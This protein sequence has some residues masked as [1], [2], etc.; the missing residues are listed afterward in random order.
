M[1]LDS[2]SISGLARMLDFKAITVCSFDCFG[3]L[4]DWE[5]GILDALGRVLARHGRSVPDE[6][7]LALY[8]ACEPAA[9]QGAFVDYKSVL[10]R[11]MDGIAARLDIDLAPEERDGLVAS[12]PSW[13]PFADTRE[14]LRRLA[15]RCRLGI[16]SNVDDDLFAATARQLG[17]PLAFVVTAESVG[18]YKPSLRMFEAA[19]DRVRVP[20]ENWLHVAQS[21]FH[22]IAPARAF[23][24]RTVHVDRGWERRG[25]GATPVSD[26]TADCTVKSLAE[27]ADLVAEV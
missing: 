21:R 13:Q 18:A 10:R 19:L 4:I 11:T 16:L 15:E 22:D 2:A 23:G 5:S 17:A 27:L 12:L 7:A 24:L 9:Q 8:A 14:A 26:A 6:D 20:K 1:S 25:S 3:T